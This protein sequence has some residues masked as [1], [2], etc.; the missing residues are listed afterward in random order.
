[1]SLEVV[2]EVVGVVV[3]WNEGIGSSIEA[4]ITWHISATWTLD[5]Q[6]VAAAA[7]VVETLICGG[8][9]TPDTVELEL[10]SVFCDEIT[11]FIVVLVVASTAVSILLVWLADR[12]LNLSF[13]TVSSA[14]LPGP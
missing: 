3:S 7:V 13:L 10:Y 14:D 1:M 8:V 4:R 6:F 9:D 2:L 12:R 5:T 11:V